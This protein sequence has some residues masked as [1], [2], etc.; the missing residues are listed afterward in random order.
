[1]STKY[2]LKKID[3]QKNIKKGDFVIINYEGDNYPEVAVEAGPTIG[4]MTKRRK[5]RT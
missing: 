5:L 3:L 4:Y 1:M 2:L